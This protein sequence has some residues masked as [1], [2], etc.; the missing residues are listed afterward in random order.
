MMRKL[1]T[2]TDNEEAYREAEAETVAKDLGLNLVEAPANVLMCDLDD[3]PSMDLFWERFGDLE[4]LDAVIGKPLITTSKSGK[5]HGYIRLKQEFSPLER[6]GLQAVLG[7][8]NKREFLSVRRVLGD[9]RDVASVLFETD[10]EI[11]KVRAFIRPA[12]D[13]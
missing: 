4:E 7:S 6:I 5:K 3:K 12:T 1:C 10:E 2:K 8:D 11:D 9:L 13:F